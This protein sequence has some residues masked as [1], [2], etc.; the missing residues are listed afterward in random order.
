MVG[1]AGWAAL[2][3]FVLQNTGAAL[4]MRFAK[5]R[6]EPY[7][8]GVAVLI[9]ELI[10][11]PISFFLFSLEVGGPVAVLKTIRTDLR[12]RPREWVQL[13][14]PAVLYLITN[15]SIYVGYTHLEAA[16]GMVM[17]QSKIIFMAVFSVSIL[18]KKISRNQWLA[19]FILALGVVAAQGLLPMPGAATAAAATATATP[20]SGATVPLIL[21]G[22]PAD[23]THRHA[24]HKS[25]GKMRG[26]VEEMALSQAPVERN[27][28]LGMGAFILG[29]VCT[30]FASVYFEKM[31]KSDSKPSL[32]LR[33]IQLASYSAVIAIVGICVN[34][35]EEMTIQGPFHGF[36]MWTWMAIFNN[37]AGGLLVA[38]I[39]KYADNILRSFAQGLAIVFGALGSYV[40]FDFQ[41]DG[42]FVLGVALVISAVFLYGAKA[43][44]PTELCE[45][46]A[47]SCLSAH[48]TAVKHKPLATAE[49]EP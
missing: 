26:L 43:E 2:A 21:P 25:G 40:L 31:I 23:K 42:S 5:S 20:V 24:H 4:L 1:Y 45:T 16:L 33:N 48:N 17:Y 3:T 35:F 28:M 44:T 37:A 13:T 47:L 29:A 49:D 9:Q 38:V 27:R 12:E 19:V 14:I 6:M 32:W 7:N 36:G 41:L 8:T 11:L 15:I 46:M 10:K 30:S 22:P 39:I 34:D 18:S